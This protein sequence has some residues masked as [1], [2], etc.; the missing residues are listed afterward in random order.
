MPALKAIPAW[1]SNGWLPPV[2]PGEL[3]S[4]AARSPYLVGLLDVVERFAT[5]PERIRILDGLLRFR[6]DLHQAGIVSGF[7]WLDGSFMEQVEMLE[8]RPPRD[9]DVVNFLDLTAIDQTSLI[10]QH[11]ALFD[12]LQ[13]KKTYALDV[14]FVEMG[15]ILNQ[16]SVRTINYWCSLWSHRRDGQW[17]GFLQIDL[18]P[19]PNAIARELLNS[20][21]SM[22]HD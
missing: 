10:Q 11:A 2:L 13:I 15:D 22:D 7:Q 19:K 3:G 5:T 1:N 17:K 20:K 18:G 4:S 8:Q 12:H 6:A 16:E 9:L 14:Y 21:G